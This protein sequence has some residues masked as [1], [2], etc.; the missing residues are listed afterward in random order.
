MTK[1]RGGIIK[2][3]FKED[4]FVKIRYRA[5]LMCNIV[6]PIVI[7]IAIYYFISPE[8][9]FIKYL[10]SIVSIN[11]YAAVFNRDNILFKFIRCYFLD[12]LWAYSLTFMLWTILG[13][14]T[15]KLTAIVILATVFVMIMESL[16]LIPFI[17]GTF[18]VLDI[19]V[20]ILAELIAVY[21]IK[22]RHYREGFYEK[23]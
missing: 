1:N 4:I 14:K 7:G 17:H 23:R 11:Q 10:N 15:A 8:V 6:I 2:I 13:N 9:D 21:I 20:E 18:D 3:K 5:F 19:L 22:I 16:Q 12:M